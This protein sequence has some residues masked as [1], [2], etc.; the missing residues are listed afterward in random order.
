MKI[1]Q[2]PFHRLPIILKYITQT[3]GQILDVG[4]SQFTLHSELQKHRD[5]VGLD[6]DPKKEPLFIRGSAN[7]LPFKPN[8][9]AVIIA[10]E[11]IEH[12]KDPTQF[13]KE[14]FLCLIKNG[15]LMITTPNRDSWWNRITKSYHH[16]WH[17]NI[18]NEYELLK[19][20]TAQGFSVKET[21]YVPYDKYT[22]G[23]EDGLP[24][25]YWLRETIHLVLPNYL[26]EDMIVIVRKTVGCS[27]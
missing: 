17:L 8:T 2:P 24:H 14:C 6:I 16:H 20:L 4:S 10:G 21:K 1:Q 13:L 25:F 26:R 19:E 15:A 18:M 9:F 27:P 7:S 12:F 3:E 11:I 5:V 22:S 23:E